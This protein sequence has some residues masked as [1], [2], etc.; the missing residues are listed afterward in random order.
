MADV[1]SVR[2]IR[3][4]HDTRH[5]GVV[6]VQRQFHGLRAHGVGLLDIDRRGDVPRRALQVVRDRV[7]VL[8]AQ[9]RLD[10]PGHG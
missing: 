4:A 2:G 1:P 7:V 5:D 9:F 6:S 10:Q 8:Q 3:G